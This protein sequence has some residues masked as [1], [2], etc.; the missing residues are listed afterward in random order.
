[1]IC[2]YFKLKTDVLTIEFSSG[3]SRTIFLA[4]VGFFNK[5]KAPYAYQKTYTPFSYNIM[6]LSAGY[7]VTDKTFAESQ[8][9]GN[10]DDI[11]R[12]GAELIIDFPEIAPIRTK[13]RLDANY[14]FTRYVDNT[15]SWDYRNDWSHTS[16]P[17]FPLFQ[18]HGDWLSGAC[19]VADNQ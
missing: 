17:H 15:L 13:F 12:T 6:T 9:P 18:L 3:R 1:M 2:C 5:T 16:L 19:V 7:K 14:S 8:L 11:Y 10:G 4:H